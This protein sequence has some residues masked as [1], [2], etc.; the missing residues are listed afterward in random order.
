L[1][2]LAYSRVLLSIQSERREAPTTNET[3]RLVPSPNRILG[4]VAAVLASLL[5]RLPWQS[6]PIEDKDDRGMGGFTIVARATT[7]C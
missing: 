6:S 7:R 4:V 3:T 1:P 5:S 2:S